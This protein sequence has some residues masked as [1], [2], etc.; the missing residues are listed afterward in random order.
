MRPAHQPITASRGSR[1]AAAQT[2]GKCRPPATAAEPET[3]SSRTTADPRGLA[4]R[5]DVITMRAAEGDWS[6]RALSASGPLRAPEAASP[7]FAPQRS[8]WT[9]PGS[10]AAGIAEGLCGTTG[11]IRVAKPAQTAGRAT[12][13]PSRRQAA[14]GR[15]NGGGAGGD[16]EEEEKEK[17]R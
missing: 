2:P 1:R 15:N 14:M 8:G 7:R 3:R 9:V 10:P 17:E 5:S 11:F 12:T 13:L 4:G 16:G 6:P